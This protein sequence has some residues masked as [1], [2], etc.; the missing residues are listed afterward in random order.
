MI[1]ALICLYLVLLVLVSGYVFVQIGQAGFVS[2]EN[3]SLGRNLVRANI[4]L[5]FHVSLLVAIV[6]NASTTIRQGLEE[7]LLYVTPLEWQRTAWGKTQVAAFVLLLFYSMTL[8]FLTLAWMLRG[9][10][11]LSILFVL[12]SGFFLEMLIVNYFTASFYRCRTLKEL[13]WMLALSIV[14]IPALLVFWSVSVLVL[15]SAVDAGGKEML[16][17]VVATL[18]GIGTGTFMTWGITS[19]IYAARTKPNEYDTGEKWFL[20]ALG[21]WII[22][23]FSIMV[24]SLFLV[25]NF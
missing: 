1:L 13:W 9:I 3:E 4:I 10:D 20:A 2:I 18:S 8:P 22:V 11:I 6:Y 25:G 24:G 16:K 23:F 21:A 14:F 12:F 7:E 5:L 17:I 19:A 15:L